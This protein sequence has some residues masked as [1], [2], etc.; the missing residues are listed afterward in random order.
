MS[1]IGKWKKVPKESQKVLLEDVRSFGIKSPTEI[2]WALLVSKDPRIYF[3]IAKTRRKKEPYDAIMLV[4]SG[5]RKG[6]YVIERSPTI[7]AAKR[8]GTNVTKDLERK[9]KSQRRNNPSREAVG[10]LLL[11]GLFGYAFLKKK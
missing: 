7:A 2:L 10:G 6:E 3:V 11:A 4:G 5:R 8:A 9:R 1:Q